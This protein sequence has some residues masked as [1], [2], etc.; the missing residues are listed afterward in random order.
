MIDLQNISRLYG[1]GD[2]QVAALKDISLTIDRNEFVA[3]MGTSGSGKSTLMNILGCL[4]SPTSGQYFLTGQQI[5]A[6]KD[7]QLSKI[8]NENIG[9]IFQSFHL[10]PRL[11]AL[12]NVTIPLRYTDV[13]QQQAD[14]RGLDML[15][16]VGLADRSHHKPFEMSGGQRQRVAIARALINDP[17]VIF[18]DEPTGNLDSTTSAEIMDLLCQLHLSGQT[19]VMVTHEESIAAYAQR[20]IRMKDGNIIEDLPCAN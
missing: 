9:F 14:Q 5:S 20:I 18:A 4:D 17:S 12:N 2:I 1:S 15:A 3:I 13:S 10:L 7:Q 11:T 6:V 19:I 8:R 16:R